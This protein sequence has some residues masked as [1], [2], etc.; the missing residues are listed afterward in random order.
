MK[1]T[2]AKEAE[3]NALLGKLDQ[4]ME[5]P[6]VKQAASQ[7]SSLTS[8]QK[9]ARIAEIRSNIDKDITRQ[10]S[11]KQQASRDL[12]AYEKNNPATNNPSVQKLNLLEKSITTLQKQK[13]TLNR[14]K[15]S[16]DALIASHSQSMSKTDAEFQKE[17]RTL[18][19]TLSIHT[20]KSLSFPHN[21]PKQYKA[22]PSCNKRIMILLTKL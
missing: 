10:T 12:S 19:S 18:D 15:D 13:E 20:Q 7:L 14:Q 1:L 9:K 5:K 17:I 2:E 11:L 16:L 22:I 3:L 4:Y 8:A 6:G 21:E